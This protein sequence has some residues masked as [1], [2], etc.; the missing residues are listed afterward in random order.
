MIIPALLLIIACLVGLLLDVAEVC[1][2]QQLYLGLMVGA[3]VG[4]ILTLAIYGW[5]DYTKG[6]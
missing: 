3:A 5:R 2:L 6:G 4:H 1:T